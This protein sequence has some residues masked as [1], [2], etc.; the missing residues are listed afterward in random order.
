M[1]SVGDVA[2][3]LFCRGAL[4]ADAGY[5]GALQ[6][7]PMVVS[8]AAAHR[9]VPTPLLT[10]HATTFTLHLIWTNNALYTDSHYTTHFYKRMVET[11]MIIP[12][13][14]S[15]TGGRRMLGN[16]HCH[17]TRFVD[18]YTIGVSGYDG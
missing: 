9:K 17:T 11:I 5:H 16:L 8:R 18:D 1:L 14:A 4:L 2:V 12:P 6:A 13:Y 3:A 7:Q 10:L 15:L